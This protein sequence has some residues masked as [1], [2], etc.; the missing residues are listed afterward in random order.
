MLMTR[1][2][3]SEK[4]HVDLTTVS[5]ALEAINPVVK[6]CEENSTLCYH[7]EEMDALEALYAYFKSKSE[8]AH[9]AYL[10]FD[11]EEDRMMDY[12]EEVNEREYHLA[13]GD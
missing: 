7:Y 12:M 6:F 11:H 4:Y 2:Q 9:N 13:F 8:E 5:T 10:F 1:K 3:L